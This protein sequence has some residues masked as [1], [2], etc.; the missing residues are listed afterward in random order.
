MN[1]LS[2]PVLKL[3]TIKSFLAKYPVFSEAWLRKMIFNRKNNGFDKVI[4]QVNRRI[5]INEEA[6][7]VWLDENRWNGSKN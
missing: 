4:I 5:I 3:L 7:F 1:V 2:E 6:F